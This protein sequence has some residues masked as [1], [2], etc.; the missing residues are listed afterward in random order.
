MERAERQAASES[1]EAQKRKIKE[2]ARKNKFFEE[3]D[4]A[5]YGTGMA[6]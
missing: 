5:F 4:E 3:P 6:D 2:L 1:K